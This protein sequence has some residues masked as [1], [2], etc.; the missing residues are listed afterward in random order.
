M[1]RKKFLK[2]FGLGV[3]AVFIAPALI[4]KENIG[5]FT[6]SSDPATGKVVVFNNGFWI[7]KKE[8]DAELKW[9]RDSERKFINYVGEQ[10]WKD[11]NK[12][13]KEAAEYYG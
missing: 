4:A 2:L 5:A 9:Q 7:H 1:N 10:G 12:A 8:W 6:T 11:L 13:L 3:G